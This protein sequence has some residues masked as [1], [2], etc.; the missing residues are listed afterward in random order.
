MF[1]SGIEDRVIYEKLF[2]VLEKKCP[3]MME[4]EL[5]GQK[6]N[7]KILKCLKKWYE[8]VVFMSLQ[9]ANL[10]DELF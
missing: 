6:V 3:E 7:S 1:F 2:E 10:T 9:G 5:M 8:S 4:V